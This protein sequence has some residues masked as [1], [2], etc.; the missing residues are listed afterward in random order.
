M[1]PYH[2]ILA[3]PAPFAPVVISSIENPQKSYSKFALLDT[4]ATMSA[5]P[6]SV[7]RELKLKAIRRRTVTGSTG[8]AKKRIYTVNITFHGVPFNGITV[9]EFNQGNFIIV[10]RDIL[11]TVHVCFDGPQKVANVV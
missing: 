11:N 8:K 4:G 9:V 6:L 1:Y 7:I 10:G 5:I 2:N 3:T